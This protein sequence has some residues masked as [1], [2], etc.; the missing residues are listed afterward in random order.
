MVTCP[1]CGIKGDYYTPLVT[2]D[3]DS[4]GDTIFKLNKVECVECQHQFLVRDVYTIKYEYGVNIVIDF[5]AD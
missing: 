1:K 3:T 4:D 5:D 2:L